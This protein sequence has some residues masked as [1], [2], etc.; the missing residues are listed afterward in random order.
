MLKSSVANIGGDF[1]TQ[2]TIASRY[3]VGIYDYNYNYYESGCT[4]NLKGN[5]SQLAGAEDNFVCDAKVVLCGDDV[6]EVYFDNPS[7][8]YFSELVLTNDKNIKFTST[9]H[10]WTVNEDTTIYQGI[11]TVGEFTLTG[12]NTLT[13]KGNLTQDIGGISVGSGTLNVEG[14]L[15]VKSGY[16]TMSNG[17]LN[18]DGDL[19]LQ[20]VTEEPSGEIIYGPTDAYLRMLKSSVANIGGD[21]VTQSTIASRYSVGIYDYNYNYYESGC[22]INLKG[23][24][25]QL[26]GAEDNFACSA[27]VVLCGDAHQ[28]VSFASCPYSKFSTL[29]LT[30]PLSNYTLDPNP[31]WDKLIEAEFEPEMPEMTAPV[32][33]PNGSAGTITTQIS[34]PESMNGK[35]ATAIA[36]F[37]D[38]NHRMLAVWMLN[39]CTLQNDGKL[40]LNGTLPQGYSSIKVFLIDE[41]WVPICSAA[42]TKLD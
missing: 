36:T 31:C 13:V 21:F 14:N 40:V 35:K 33:Q 19:R 28:T 38:V 27:K 30:K 25:S 2:S 8:S 29:C 5:F 34:C 11:E 17:T 12:E 39:D 7:A 41:Y 26:A 42:S 22:T 24:F 6:Q 37:Y 32:L 15:L 3:S 20:S 23:N 10:G 18:V 1:V 9:I 16:L 4:I